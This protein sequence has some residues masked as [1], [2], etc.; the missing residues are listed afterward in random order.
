MTCPP[1]NP[2]SWPRLMRAETAAA[3]CDEQSVEA[4]Q[5]RVGS[6]YPRP[7]NVSGRG[8]VWLKEHLDTA[9]A[10]MIGG[11][12]DGQDAVNLL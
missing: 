2:G 10:G 9:I 1:N 11:A 6:V 3:Y 7:L 4:F 5:K 12:A 8:R